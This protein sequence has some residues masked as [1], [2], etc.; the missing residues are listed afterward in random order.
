MADL[1]NETVI[2]YTREKDS[3][4]NAAE[5]PYAN[6]EITLSGNFAMVGDVFTEIREYMDR[7]HPEWELV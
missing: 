5:E 3:E 7:K 2:K 1:E 6:L 4:G